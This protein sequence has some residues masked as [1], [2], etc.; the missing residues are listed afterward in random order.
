M[1]TLA[2]L[3][4]GKHSFNHHPPKFPLFTHLQLDQEKG[5][6]T[7]TFV[8]IQFS[9]LFV[10]P[11]RLAVQI[12]LQIQRTKEWCPLQMNIMRILF[13]SKSSF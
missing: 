13:E 8:H 4:Q 6:K 9:P 1:N 5:E 11:L 3:L 2:H 7:N 12:R 10:K